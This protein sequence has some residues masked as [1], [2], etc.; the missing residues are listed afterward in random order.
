LSDEALAWLSV[1]SKVKIICIWSKLTDAT[2][3]QS[4][5]AS[6]KSRMVFT[7]LLLAYPGCL[8]KEAIKRVFV[9]LK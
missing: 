3:T 4:F 6:L 2:T 9:C 7:F 8:G 1:G 5:L